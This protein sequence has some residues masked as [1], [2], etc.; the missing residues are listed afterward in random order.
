MRRWAL[1]LIGFSA[2]SGAALA[3][4]NEAAPISWH[5]RVF[6][7]WTN[8]AWQRKIRETVANLF[9]YRENPTVWYRE[10][11]VL[12]LEYAP[13]GR[14]RRW[15]TTRWLF[16][17]SQPSLLSADPEVLSDEYTTYYALKL[18]TD[19]TQYVAL[20]PVW[21]RPSML[22]IYSAWDFAI[23]GDKAWI[24]ALCI[25]REGKGYPIWLADHKG[26]PLLRL[27]LGCPEHLRFP[28]RWIYV[29]LLGVALLG[30]LVYLWRYLK[31][32][33]KSAPLI[34][35]GLLVAIWQGLH[36]LDLPGRLLHSDFFSAKL[37]AISPLHTS[38]WDLVWTIGI[39]FW[40]ASLLRHAP[41]LPKFGY[42]GGYWG[43]WALFGA[44]IY[45]I[46]QHSQIE[47]DP[48]RQPKL[49][50]LLAWGIVLTI[51]R[52][53]V[54]YLHQQA[55]PTL[56]IYVGTA[57]IGGSLAASVG[58]PI[59]SIAALIALYAL[60]RF[61]KSLPA[62]ASVMLNFLLLIGIVNGWIS[63]G[64]VQRL[65]LVAQA[66]AIQVSRLRDPTIEYRLA[67]LI[68]RIA[69]DTS[70][71]K[72][73]SL[74]DYLIDSRFISRIIQ[75]YL[76]SFGDS[77]E[78]V[79]SCWK[80]EGG[81][82]D[83]LFELRPLPWR[84]VVSRSERISF[85][86]NLYFVTH[87]TPR[88]FYVARIPIAL[89]EV[90]PLEVQIELH[91]RTQ[92]L[93]SRLRS[94]LSPT[95]PPYAL[96]ENGQL[97]RWWGDVRFPSFLSVQPR[98]TPIWRETEGQYEY[99]APVSRNLIVYVRLPARDKAAVLAAI[100][101]FLSLLTL[102]LLVERFAVVRRT[103][104]SLYTREASFVQRFQ[105][106]FGAVVFLPLLAILSV[107]F[108]LFLRINQTQRQQELTQKLSS[109]SSYLAGESILLEKLAYWLENYLAGEESFVRDLMRRIGS[110]SQSEAFI[111]TSE[112]LL[113]S[114]T[115]PVAYWNELASPRVD[116]QILERMRRA[117][118][119]TLIEMD[120]PRGRLMGY[121]PLRTETGKL[122][123]ILHIPQPIPKES[124]YE[125]L[126]YFIGYTVNTYLFLSLGAMMVGL[127]LIERFAGG[128]QRLILQLRSA[129]EA[130]DPPLL[131]WE[132]GK[133][134]IAT[135]VAAYNEM[136]ERLRASQR[137]L[138]RTLRRVSQQEMAFQAAHEIKTAL[139]P[140]KIHLQHLQRLPT[141]DPEKLREISTRL[142]QRI[143]ALVRIANAFMSFA[144]L[145]STEELSLQPINLNAFLEEQL[146][147]FAQ[148]PHI[149][150]I[151]ELPPQPLWIEGNPDALQQILN[152]LIQN[153]LQVLE[154]ASAPFIRASLTQ[155]GNQAVIAIQDNGP[156]I[157]PEVQEKIFEFYFTTRRTGTGLGL[158][159]TK[160]LVE[161]MGGRISFVSEVGVGTTFYVSFPLKNGSQS[162]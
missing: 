105:V 14:L 55:L 98:S 144:K 107:T 64:Q 66:H 33:Y 12:L 17:Q 110:L 56:P 102:G 32:K 28:L 43:L 23:S 128:L 161:R 24:K 27:Y 129:P 22:S 108:L 123:G 44:G 58:L 21:A 45:L 5:G 86:S 84:Q 106:L 1:R 78:V 3:L 48:L 51:L 160:G 142:L 50:Y 69:S 53:V 74:N 125:P 68:P 126:R 113:Y 116:Y 97:I 103:I 118:T 61:H 60:P 88:Y 87:G 151:Q 71:W 119:G 137:Q 8:Y 37:F 49:I 101:I 57:I 31:A 138:E 82:A 120:A 6:Q 148:N 59:W 4:L 26:Q 94:D 46:S 92:P 124:F 18:F 52:Q 147:P 47:L 153:A 140:L 83:N 10:S 35:L 158:A 156:G 36:W 15:N 11:D 149:T 79:V 62:Y 115:L 65:R 20:L 145:G 117:E 2:I 155:E 85:A 139:T 81:R 19:S 38:L 34:Y 127:F 133:D 132:G 135:L 157:P 13:S 91:P 76:F 99:I 109:V 67:H 89:P 41:P 141:I 111:Y 80:P 93:L 70:L 77:Y 75:K 100:P 146:Q 42:I 7:A 104:R 131:H 16:P 130:P 159:I 134:E 73:L 112:G 40:A 9:T 152:N 90:P 122:L 114:S 162:A 143:D 63:W 29:G 39:L 54:D 30:G 95:Q 136:V 150:F 25:N 154:G 96:Y 121:A 72:S